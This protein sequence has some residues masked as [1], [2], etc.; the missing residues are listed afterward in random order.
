MRGMVPQLTEAD[1][2]ILL[3]AQL[4]L[5]L[6]RAELGLRVGVGALLRT[7]FLVRELDGEEPT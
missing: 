7:A 2:R 5:L 3:I 1:R 4:R 6:R